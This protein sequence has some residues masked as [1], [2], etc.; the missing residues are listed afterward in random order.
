MQVNRLGDGLFRPL[1]GEARGGLSVHRWIKPALCLAGCVYQQRTAAVATGCRAVAGRYLLFVFLRWVC[2]VPAGR[3]LRPFFP[4]L[5]SAVR[6]SGRL[7]GKAG[8]WYPLRCGAAHNRKSAHPPA[9]RLPAVHILRHAG[10]NT[11]LITG[12]LLQQGPCDY[13][14]RGRGAMPLQP[15]TQTGICQMQT[16]NRQG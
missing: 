4:I 13:S 6:F 1:S 14:R 15:P 12:F 8:K 10:C 9:P 2:V 7:P 3:F 11:A 16:G 5:L